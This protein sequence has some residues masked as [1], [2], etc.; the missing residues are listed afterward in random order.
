MEIEKATARRGKTNRRIKLPGGVETY[1]ST[2]PEAIARTLRAKS[3]LGLREAKL[4]AAEK[5]IDR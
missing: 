2:L 3:K 1:D 5:K 4:E